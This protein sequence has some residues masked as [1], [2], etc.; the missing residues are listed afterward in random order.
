MFLMCET[1]GEVLAVGAGA[2]DEPDCCINWRGVGQSG[3]GIQYREGMLD[4]S[5]PAVVAVHGED[6]SSDR[7]NNAPGA[8][9]KVTRKGSHLPEAP[10]R[11]TLWGRAA[12]TGIELDPELSGEVAGGDAGEHVRLVPDPDPDR[13]VI[14]SAMRPELGKSTLLR[15]PA[16][17]EGN[18]LTRA[19]SLVGDDDLEFVPVFLGSDQ[20]L[21]GGKA[22]ERHRNGEFSLRRMQLLYYG[23]VEEGTV[24]AGFNIRM[25]KAWDYMAH[26]VDDE[27]IS[28]VGIVDVPRGR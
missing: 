27:D 4:L 20:I 1:E 21:E 28:P 16:L 5:F 17:V 22:L 18:D 6:Q 3:G 13:Y 25:R 9:D 2:S 15:R 23:F 8:P 19:Y 12:G 7:S 11:G 14:H 10:R 24:D 26:T